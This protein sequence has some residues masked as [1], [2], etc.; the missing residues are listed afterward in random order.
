MNSEIRD[1]IKEEYGNLPEKVQ[2]QLWE[3]YL[4]MKDALKHER[5]EHAKTRQDLLDITQLLRSKT[6]SEFK[7]N[8]GVINPD[9]DESPWIQ[10]T[11]PEDVI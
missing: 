3:T 5:E 4:L 1:R 7:L 10:Q 8:G 2:I 11:I 9:D 6:N